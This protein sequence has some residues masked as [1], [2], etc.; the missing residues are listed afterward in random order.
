[1]GRGLTDAVVGHAAFSKFVGV[2]LVV[3]GSSGDVFW[4]EEATSAYGWLP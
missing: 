4:P 1:M 3:L 2:A